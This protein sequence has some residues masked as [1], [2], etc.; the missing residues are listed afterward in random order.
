MKEMK[1]NAAMRTSTDRPFDWV[2]SLAVAAGMV[3][4]VS[5]IGALI[6]TLVTIVIHFL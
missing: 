2:A 6:V 5:G 3:V 4:I 1:E